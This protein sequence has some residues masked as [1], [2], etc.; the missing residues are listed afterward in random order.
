MTKNMKIFQKINKSLAGP[1]LLL[2]RI[3][4]KTLSPDQSWRRVY[5]P[6]GFCRYWP[7]C[8]EY[9]HQALQKYGLFP[10][11]LKAAARILRCHPLAKGGY[12]PLV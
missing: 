12:D 3:Y 8:S 6:Q 10:G 2:I 7:H 5:Y 11:T 4:Q 9:G 1:A